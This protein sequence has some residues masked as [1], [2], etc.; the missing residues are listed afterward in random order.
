M[1]KIL[2]TSFLALTAFLSSFAQN[3]IFID[4]NFKDALLANTSINKDGNI[5]EISLTEAAAV[6]TLD[7]SGKSI[8]DLTGIEAFTGLTYLN[9]SENL[10]TTLDVSKN[11]KLEYL[12]CYD[13]QLTAL[14]LSKNVKLKELSCYTNKLDTLDVSKNVVLEYLDCRYNPL[15][16]LDVS[17]NL[18]L[19]YLKCINEDQ[20]GL[21]DTI[22]IN[23]AHENYISSWQKN[24]NADAVILHIAIQEQHSPPTTP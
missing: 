8:K 4:Y 10:L 15:T 2:L 22:Y 13:N 16:T 9:C 5:I 20:G 11:V 1:K 21:L 19:K 3:V 14:D 17:K 12:A 18:D 24:A 23:Q 6:T 7:V